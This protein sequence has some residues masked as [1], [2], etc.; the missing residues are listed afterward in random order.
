MLIEKVKDTKNEIKMALLDLDLRDDVAIFK[1]G[2][3]VIIVSPIMVQ[4]QI[5][6]MTLTNIAHDLYRFD[7]LLE[8]LEDEEF[9]FAYY[10]PYRD[11]DIYY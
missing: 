9:G 10:K 8:Y 11:L 1:S 2:H 5:H 7:D 3:E 4:G 6:F